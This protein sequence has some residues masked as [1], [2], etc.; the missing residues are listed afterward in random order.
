MTE[1]SKGTISKGSPTV[2][3][4]AFGQLVPSSDPTKIVINSCFSDISWLEYKK[5]DGSLYNDVPG[6]KHRT[7]VLAQDEGGTWKIDQ[8]AMNVV[9]TC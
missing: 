5:S 6:G 1:Q 9:G 7:Q 3:D 2:T 8:L 4:I